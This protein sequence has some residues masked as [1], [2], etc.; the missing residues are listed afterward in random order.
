MNTDYQSNPIYSAHQEPIGLKAVSL[1]AD[2]TNGKSALEPRALTANM[3]RDLLGLAGGIGCVA[4]Q[5]MGAHFTW[6]HRLLG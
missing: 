1:W 3:R 6:R 4:R 5:F 2:D